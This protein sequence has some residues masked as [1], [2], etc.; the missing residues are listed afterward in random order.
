[1]FVVRMSPG[2]SVQVFDPS[3]KMIGTIN[4]MTTKNGYKANGFD[5][6]RAYG[7]RHVRHATTVCKPVV[8]E[9]WEVPEEA[10]ND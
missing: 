9:Q 7:L 3:G 1:M 5:F 2:D 4:L 10:S 6:P 8:E